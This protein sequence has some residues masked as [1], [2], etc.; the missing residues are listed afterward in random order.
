MEDA[1]ARVDFLGFMF[2]LMVL[3]GLGYAMG[4]IHGRAVGRQSPSGTW[5]ES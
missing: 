4:F 3:I 2:E 1:A 5:R